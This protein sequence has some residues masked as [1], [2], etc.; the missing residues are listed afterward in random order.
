MVEI[1]L[2]FPLEQRDSSSSKLGD[3]GSGEPLRTPKVH[4]EGFQRK[5]SAMAG[6]C[7]NK[8]E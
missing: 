7:F 6:E 2:R 1:H 5:R 3:H 4:K 8:A